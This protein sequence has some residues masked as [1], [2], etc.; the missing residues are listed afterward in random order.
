VDDFGTGF[1]S[2][3]FVTRVRV[4]ELKVDRSFVEAMTDSAAATAV[5]RGAVELGDRLGAR[6]VAEGVET[7]E[8]RLALL[9][10]GCVSAQGFHFCQPLPTDKIIGALRQLNDAAAA[11]VLPLRA[12]DAS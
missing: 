9:K 12:D 11:R 2:L 5:V 4:D 7:A 3:S 8:Q 10:L 6:V 1:S